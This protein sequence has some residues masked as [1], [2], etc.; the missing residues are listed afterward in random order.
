MSY[1]FL[2]AGI[3]KTFHIY[4]G[5][6][7]FSEPQL[8]AERVRALT[9]LRLFEDYQDLWVIT[10]DWQLW[11]AR[12]YWEQ[13][14]KGLLRPRFI[15]VR[16]TGGWRTRT[17]YYAYGLLIRAAMLTG[18]APQLEKLLTKYVY[19]PRYDRGFR[20]RGCA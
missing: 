9:T 5:T 6:G 17:M 20:M 18:L 10:S 11:A 13:A 2:S 4:G 15:V 14:F 16:G 12:P 19:Q 1:R 8:I 7:T 3:E